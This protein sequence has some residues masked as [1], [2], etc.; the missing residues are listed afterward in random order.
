MH[1][2]THTHKHKTYI[3]IVVTCPGILQIDNGN[4]NNNNTPTG[5]SS[6]SSLGGVCILLTF[7]LGAAGGRRNGMIFRMTLPSSWNC[8]S[9]ALQQEAEVGAGGC[10][11][12]YLYQYAG[13]CDGALHPA[14]HQGASGTHAGCR[15]EVGII[16]Y[17]CRPLCG[18]CGFAFPS[19]NH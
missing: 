4:S 5:V 14:R 16:R 8:N 9:D 18:T 19:A 17:L 13:T 1:V 11:R 12:L 2:C 7:V 3:L 15:T 6:G 10:H